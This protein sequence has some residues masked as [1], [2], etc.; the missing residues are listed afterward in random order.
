[1][2]AFGEIAESLYSLMKCFLHRY[3]SATPRASDDPTIIPYKAA[4]MLL[5]CPIAP[6]ATFAIETPHLR[7]SIIGEC[8]HS[9]IPIFTISLHDFLGHRLNLYGLA[10]PFTQVEKLMP[11]SPPSEDT[12]DVAGPERKGKIIIHAIRDQAFPLRLHRFTT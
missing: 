3:F 11:T 10:P 6:R 1:M 2:T 7:W 9:G 8:R 4:I 12:M 5:P